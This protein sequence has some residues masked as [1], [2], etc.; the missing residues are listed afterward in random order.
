[1]N[2]KEFESLRIGSRVSISHGRD[3]PPLCGIC[4]D[5][6]VN[7]NVRS[8]LIK[9]KGKEKHLYTWAAVSEVKREEQSI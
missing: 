1:M 4:A 2:M 5:I 6:L 8:V 9:H 7:G 3:R